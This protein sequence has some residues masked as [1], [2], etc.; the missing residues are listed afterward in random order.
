MVYKA[1]NTHFMRNVPLKF[2]PDELRRD[3]RALERFQREAQAASPPDHPHIR[4]IDDGDEADGKPFTAMEW[5]ERDN[6]HCRG[7]MRTYPSVKGD[8]R[9]W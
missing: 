4:T 6:G 1:K 3:R 5:L 9:A 2:L 7:G 8:A